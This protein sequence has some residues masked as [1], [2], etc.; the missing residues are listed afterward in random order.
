LAGKGE[1][2]RE[3]RKMSKNLF[4]Q[5][6]NFTL[7]KNFRKKTF[8]TVY[9]YR[10]TESR[11]VDEQTYRQMERQTDRQ[12]ERQTDRQMERQTERQIDR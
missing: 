8:F 11:L 4:D 7:S 1:K 2:L 12:M 6:K 9:S 5:I 3:F 10:K